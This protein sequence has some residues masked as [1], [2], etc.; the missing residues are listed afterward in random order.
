MKKQKLNQLK[1]LVEA[2]NRASQQIEEIIKR[3]LE[4]PPV[5]EALTAAKQALEQAQK[6]KR[7]HRCRICDRHECTH[8]ERVFDDNGQEADM[9]YDPETGQ[10]FVDKDGRRI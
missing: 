4:V 10:Y 2:S 7:T 6:Q 1:E 8:F 5:K 9:K 3:K